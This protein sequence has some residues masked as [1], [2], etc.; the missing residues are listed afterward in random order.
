MCSALGVALNAHS[1]HYRLVLD[2]FCR[3]PYP[4]LLAGGN[5]DTETIYREE[6]GN[7]QTSGG[8]LQ[9]PYSAEHKDSK[10]SSGMEGGDHMLTGS[11]VTSGVM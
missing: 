7:K 1:S 5:I 9:G 10:S 2:R 3:K 11:G 6:G 4:A 8:C